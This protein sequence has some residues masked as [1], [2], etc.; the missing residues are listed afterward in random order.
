[1]IVPNK[2]MR[3][4]AVGRIA[5]LVAMVALLASGGCSLFKSLGPAPPPLQED[6]STLRP[7]EFPTKIK[8]LEEISQ[9]DKSASV[10]TRA[11]FY[12]ALAH[13][14]Y[15]NPSPD[16]PQAV[17]YLDKYIALESHRKDGD[18]IVAW[19]SVVQT[20]DTSL[21]Q[22]EK[23][24]KDYAQLKQQYDSATKNRDLS[25]KKVSDLNLTIESQKK[26]I[27][28]LKAT[29]KRLDTVQQEIEKKRKGIRK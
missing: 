12:L 1:M 25:A 19:K 7:E 21:Q 16:Y 23:L 9:N 8:Q 5:L 24:K 11:L 26:E 20:L 18:E 10:R 22:H 14:H 15:K 29:I 28:G 27:E 4:G 3:P 6:F 13:V 2:K 17:Q